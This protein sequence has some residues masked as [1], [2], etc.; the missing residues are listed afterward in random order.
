MKKEAFS[1]FLDWVIELLRGE[2]DYAKRDK[3]TPPCVDFLYF[4]V[5]IFWLSILSP[6]THCTHLEKIMH[7]VV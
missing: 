7:S 1:F 5:S 2:M 3:N 4:Y 6:P